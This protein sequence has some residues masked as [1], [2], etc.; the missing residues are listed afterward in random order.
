[1]LNPAMLSAKGGSADERRLLRLARS[2][3]PQS[4]QTLLAFA[5]FLAERAADS[6]AAQ[7]TAPIPEP[8][9]EERPA[10]ESIVA[11]IKRLRRG[12][13]MLDAS[14]ML[15]ETSSLMTQHVLQGRQT[16]A[17]IDDLEALFAA[18]YQALKDA[19]G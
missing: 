3:D 7:P 10:Q 16:A 5:E 9:L 11:A 13:P 6:D 15:Q 19:S 14:T 1:M 17:V 2:L 18:R 4:K 12:Y 8:V